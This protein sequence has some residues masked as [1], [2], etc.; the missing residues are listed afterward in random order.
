MMCVRCARLTEANVFWR[1]RL[2]LPRLGRMVHCV[3]HWS[4]HALL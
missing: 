2:G 3:E 4:L 1:L